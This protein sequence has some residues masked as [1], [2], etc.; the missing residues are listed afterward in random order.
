MENTAFK[1]VLIIG[2]GGIGELVARLWLTEKKPVYGLA[3]SQDKQDEMHS[4]GVIPIQADLD[5]PHTL[6]ALPVNESLIYWFAPP[7]AQGTQDTRIGNFIAAMDTQQPARIVAISTTGVYGDQQGELVSE[8]TPPNPMVDR[9]RRRCDMESRLQAWAEPRGV[10]V[11]ILRVGGIYGPDRLPLQRIRDG[12]P[13]LKEALAPKTNRIHAED[14]ALICQR[15][16]DRPAGSRIYNVSDGQDSNMTEYFYTLADYFGLP[17][18]PAVDWPEAERTISPG[19]LSY[20]RESRRIDSRRMQQELDVTLRYPTLLDGLRAM[21]EAQKGL[22][23][24]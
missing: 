7:P 22:P 18:P 11:I 2:Y 19:M 16:A 10:P 20:L 15:V 13:V 17:R 6:Q 21:T 5:K 14:L 12:V 9:A 24:T 23:E 1:Q 3:R 4:A 8:E